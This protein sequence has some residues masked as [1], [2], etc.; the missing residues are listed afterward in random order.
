VI[1]VVVL[2]A[3]AGYIVFETYEDFTRL[4]ALIGIFSLIAVG[5]VFSGEFSPST[6]T[7]GLT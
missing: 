7:T 4:R 5:F 6:G 2:A 1:I 3:L